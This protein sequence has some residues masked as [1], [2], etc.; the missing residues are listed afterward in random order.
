[1][2]PLRFPTVREARALLRGFEL[3]KR[4]VYPAL[5]A[6]ANH[7]TVYIAYKR[8][9]VFAA[10]I[11][12]N[13]SRSEEAT[14]PLVA[15]GEPVFMVVEDE[16]SSDGM[17]VAPHVGTSVVTARMLL[18]A[19]IDAAAAGHVEFDTGTAGG[20][21]TP[22]FEKHVRFLGIA[23]EATPTATEVFANPGINVAFTVS[24]HGGPFEL[25]IRVRKNDV[26][27]NPV[28]TFG[29]RTL[30]LFLNDSNLYPRPGEAR[31][32]YAAVRGVFDENRAA[33]HDLAGVGRDIDGEFPS[34]VAYLAACE[35]CVN[36][37]VRGRPV[38]EV[39]AAMQ[40]AAARKADVVNRLRDRG[41][42]EVAD[43]VDALPSLYAWVDART[44][45]GVDRYEFSNAHLTPALRVM[46][47]T[48][49]TRERVAGTDTAPGFH[50][51]SNVVEIKR[52]PDPRVY[53]LVGYI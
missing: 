33:L 29:G 31:A 24:G 18:A 7:R 19:K 28:G 2:P 44:L 49:S 4:P 21:Y 41:G 9:D 3:E 14:S 1:M 27:P 12:N 32:W 13:R 36:D 8:A 38:A 40:D 16:G 50:L 45:D 34:I 37:V 17:R 10:H 11:C 30:S 53:F 20:A 48:Q 15:Y 39:R 25:G 46:M 26:I 43:K 47:L 51:F 35:A 42:D 23:L 22:F 6:R 5:D 52:T